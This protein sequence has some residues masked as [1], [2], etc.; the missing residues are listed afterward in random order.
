MSSFRLEAATTKGDLQS[1]CVISKKACQIMTP[2][3]QTFYKHCNGINSD[4]VQLKADKSVF[5][6][7]D[8]IVQTLLI[9]FLFKDNFG[10]I[11]G[12]EDAEVNIVDKSVGYKVD[13]L[14]VPNAFIPMIDQVRD[15]ITELSAEINTEAYKSLTIFID[16]IDGTRYGI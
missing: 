10:S 13:G 9:N 12:E 15:E 16:P 7:A 3:V 1:L 8:G 2:M 5:T 6:I 4:G 14:E 11:V